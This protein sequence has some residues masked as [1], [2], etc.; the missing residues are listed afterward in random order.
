M[1]YDKKMALLLFDELSCIYAD[2]ICK[3]IDLCRRYPKVASEWEQGIMA[4]ISSIEKS[5]NYDE[6]E[7]NEH[8][9]KLYEK[10]TNEKWRISD[11]E[12]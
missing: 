11:Y 7:S 2:D 1:D 6:N 10:I 12:I 9:N 4:Y 5:E 8:R 3:H